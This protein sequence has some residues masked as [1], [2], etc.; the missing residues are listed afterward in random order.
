MI[1]V[2]KSRCL[3]W[4]EYLRKAQSSEL[5][6]GLGEVGYTVRTSINRVVNI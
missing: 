2:A 1:H 3:G 5:L 4:D 6:W